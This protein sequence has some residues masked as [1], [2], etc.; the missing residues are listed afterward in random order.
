MAVTVSRY[1]YEVITKYGFR[2]ADSAF[3]PFFEPSLLSEPIGK[4]AIVSLIVT[5]RI[6]RIFYRLHLQ[7]VPLISGHGDDI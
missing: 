6:L 4:L 5:S 2:D 7:S 3:F 1:E